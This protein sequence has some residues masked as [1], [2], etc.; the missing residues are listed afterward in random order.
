MSAIIS[1]MPWYE[2][3]CSHKSLSIMLITSRKSSFN[4][5]QKL[6]SSSH[7]L[8]FYYTRDRYIA[9]SW[10]YPN[11]FSRT[12]YIHCSSSACRIPDRKV[13]LF[14]PPLI[15]TTP[16]FF[17]DNAR[18]HAT[19]HLAAVPFILIINNLRNLRAQIGKISKKFWIWKEGYTYIA[20]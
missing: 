18:L 19:S 20:D 10:R 6:R 15:N 8:F 3:W 2:T 1:E 7:F 14:Y 4:F 13:A 11:L 5:Y 9:Q 12:C 17:P 16:N